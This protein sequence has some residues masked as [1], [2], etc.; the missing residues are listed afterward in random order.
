[1]RFEL[2]PMQLQN[3]ETRSNLVNRQTYR[4]PPLLFQVSLRDIFGK[5]CVCEGSID[6]DTMTSRIY[7]AFGARSDTLGRS[8][9]QI[10]A[11]YLALSEILLNVSS[12]LSSTTRF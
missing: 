2:T 5:I 4:F 12:T 6:D 1:M 3:I 7:F 8:G 11:M 10:E 9:V